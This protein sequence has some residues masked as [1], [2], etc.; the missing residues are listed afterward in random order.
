MIRLACSY[1]L[2]VFKQHCISINDEKITVR[3]GS[4]E[5]R[6]ILRRRRCPINTIRAMFFEKIE[7]NSTYRLDK[8]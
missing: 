2:L 8:S 1:N 3:G 5:Y 7:S 6:V 4:I